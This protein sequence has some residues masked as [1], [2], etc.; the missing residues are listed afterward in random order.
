MAAQEDGATFVND[1]QL[2]G[3]EAGGGGG[4]GG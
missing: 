1:A 4:G 2:Y 3:G